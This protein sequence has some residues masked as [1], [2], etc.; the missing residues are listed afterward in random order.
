MQIICLFTVQEGRSYCFDQTEIIYNSGIN[1]GGGLL[2]S[3][4]DEEQH[5]TMNCYICQS[6]C[7]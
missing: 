7:C 2:H 6:G 4:S 3:E 5:L 1:K